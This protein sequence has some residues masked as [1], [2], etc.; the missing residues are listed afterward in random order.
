MS[1]TSDSKQPDEAQLPAYEALPDSERGLS[2]EAE[3]LFWTLN[4]P[5][6]T[7]LWVMERRKAP[8]FWEP[9]FKGTSLHPA[10][11]SPITSSKVSSIT[12]SID[13]LELYDEDEVPVHWDHTPPNTAAEVT[14]ENKEADRLVIKPDTSSGRDFVTI[15][16]YVSAV[17]PWLMERRGEIL[18]AKGLFEKDKA[19][20]PPET[21]LMVD[22]LVPDCVEIPVEEEWFKRRNGLR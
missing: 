18:G 4:G 3:L 8:E 6:T 19:P 20:L 9:Y 7:S 13:E 16:D 17:H 14:E 21:R 10:S 22:C 12:V 11:Q 5:L 2:P 15:H 1:S